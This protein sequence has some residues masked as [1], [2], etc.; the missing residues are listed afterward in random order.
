M[1]IKAS[2]ILFVAIAALLIAASAPAKY[3]HT[4]LA[5]IE[6]TPTG[7]ALINGTAA[8][9][10][11]LNVNLRVSWR[12]ASEMRFRNKGYSWTD[13]EEC[14]STKSWTLS[15]GSAGQRTVYAQFKNSSGVESEISSDTIV[16]AADFK[17]SALSAPTGA[18]ADTTIIVTNTIKN[19]SDVKAGTS[20]ASVYLSADANWDSRDTTLTSRIIAPL[21]AWASDATASHV[22]IPGT[23]EPGGYYLI[24]KANTKRT[25]TETFEG[26]NMRARPIRIG[27]DL[28][29]SVL[30]APLQSGTGGATL[31]VTDTVANVSPTMSTSAST[32]GIYFSTNSTVDTSDILLG[33]RPVPP[34]APGEISTGAAEYTLPVTTAGKYYIIA[35][36]DSGDAIFEAYENNNV[37]SRTMQLGADLSI[38]SLV[39]S[40]SAVSGSVIS[41]KEATKNNSSGMAAGPSTTSFYLSSDTTLDASDI[42]LGE[43]AVPGLDLRGSSTA[44]ALYTLPAMAP[45]AWYI[46]GSADN[47]DAVSEFNELNNKRS[48]LITIL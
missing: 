9:T 1:R 43:R 23:L 27:P 5:S 46:I 33:T 4:S 3:S 36:A 18:S 25:V 40:T 10:A 29:V 37:R 38:L 30:S 7:S 26:N 19:F 24:V 17:V 42:L 34:L 39:A 48:R 35:R 41:I 20:T 28:M 15:S 6:A 44:S 22:L 2:I 8:Y 32:T 14:T 47:A 21:A 11:L 31:T 16:T 45:G 12:N 13:W